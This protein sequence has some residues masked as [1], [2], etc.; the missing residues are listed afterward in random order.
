MV[1]FFALLNWFK[2]PSYYFAGLFDL[3][4]LGQVLWLLP[5][6]PLSIW[7]GKNFVVRLNKEI[8]DRVIIGLLGL[9]AIFLLLG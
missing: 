2:V 6:L 5:L 7:L 4:L 3:E 1:L 8:F 9:S